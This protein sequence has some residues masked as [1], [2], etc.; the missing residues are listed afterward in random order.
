MPAF[1]SFLSQVNQSFSFV[2]TIYLVLCW[3]IS[4]MFF[5]IISQIYRHLYGFGCASILHLKLSTAFTQMTDNKC[6]LCILLP[7]VSKQICRILS[8]PQF[9]LFPI[10]SI[11]K[12]IMIF[13]VNATQQ[14]YLCNFGSWHHVTYF[15]KLLGLDEKSCDFLWHVITD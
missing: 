15:G 12:C 13:R 11:A 4:S 6:Y 10:T 14:K 2:W 1:S 8:Q 7:G 5:F 3:Q 9:L